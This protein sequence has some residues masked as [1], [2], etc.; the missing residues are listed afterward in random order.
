MGFTPR[1][2]QALRPH[3]VP[4]L[5]SQSAHIDK[6]RWIA[7]KAVK[8]AQEQLIKQRGHHFIPYKSGDK[9]WLEGTNLNTTHTINKFRPKRYRPFTI[10]NVI[11]DVAYQLALPPHWKIH[12]VFH[13]SLLTP[14]HET[15]IHGPNYL[16]PP[17]DVVDSEPEWEVEEVVGTRRFGWKGYSAAHNLWE[18]AGNMHAPKLIEDFLKKQQTK[19]KRATMSDE[20]LPT[21]LNL[22]AMDPDTTSHSS[23]PPS[24]SPLYTLLRMRER[25]GLSITDAQAAAMVAVLDQPDPAEHPDMT[26][27]PLE[28]QDVPVPGSPAYSPTSPTPESSRPST[29]DLSYPGPIPVHHSEINIDPAM[30]AWPWMDRRRYPASASLPYRLADHQNPQLLDYTRLTL[31]SITGEP[32][33]V[34]TTGR[35]EPQY[36]AHLFT[37]PVP[38]DPAMPIAED[39]WHKSPLG[40]TTAF[41]PVANQAIWQLE[42]ARVWADIIHMRKEDARNPE[43]RHWEARVRQLEDFALSE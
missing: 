23:T 11:S 35:G 1:T 8:H 41:D 40:A 32:T 7:Q 38:K 18:P 3:K 24:P 5:V 30:P 2:H 15:T 19:D 42:D 16:E 36:A 21:Q 10:I 31:D 27:E 34:S 39:M 43:F 6:L 29:S 12:N 22:K 28:P 4:N 20:E 25:T 26:D 9:V 37:T 17:P 33:T 13:A 14:Y